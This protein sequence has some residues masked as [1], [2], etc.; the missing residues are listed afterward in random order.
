MPDSGGF[1]AA[2]ARRRSP[3]FDLVRR[4]V[5]GEAEGRGGAGESEERERRAGSEERTRRRPWRRTGARAVS[6]CG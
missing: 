6:V 3:A 1:C 5:R 4:V 2:G